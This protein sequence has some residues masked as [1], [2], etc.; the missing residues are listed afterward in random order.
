MK[1]AIE[2]SI[3]TF[4]LESFSFIVTA[5][6]KISS[7]TSEVKWSGFLTNFVCTDTLITLNYWRQ[8]FDLTRWMWARFHI[9]FFF[10]IVLR[11]WNYIFFRRFLN[12]FLPHR[13]TTWASYR[14]VICTFR[15][16]V[17]ASIHCIRNHT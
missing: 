15:N 4:W 7:A 8:H 9:F 13:G 5:F 10:S 17:A 6:I 11:P 1:H 12:I 14:I 16:F 3:I 2:H